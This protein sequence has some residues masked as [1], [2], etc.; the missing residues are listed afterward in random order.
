MIDGSGGQR[1]RTFRSC[2]TVHHNAADID[3]NQ[4]E[5]ETGSMNGEQMIAKTAAR[6]RQIPEETELL[7]VA[8]SE[9]LIAVDELEK[10]LS[11]V[12]NEPR[13]EAEAK[14]QAPPEQYY[15]PLADWL[16]TQRRRIQRAGTRITDILERCEL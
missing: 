12:I 15:G 4:H 9:L 6:A 16:R 8:V 5:E 13:P 7:E 3:L 10:R 11:P 1:T 14:T 2:R